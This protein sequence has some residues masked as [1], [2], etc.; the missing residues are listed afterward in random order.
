MRC[1]FGSFAKIIKLLY[2][3]RVSEKT[4]EGE[5]I[6]SLPEQLDHSDSAIKPSSSRASCSSR[7]HPQ[8][9]SSKED[10]DLNFFKILL[11]HVRTFFAFDK[12]EYRMRVMK[13]TQGFLKPREKQSSSCEHN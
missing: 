5:T 6:R 4:V 1:V 13:L 8:K 10:K 12:I 2:K 7:K 9:S 3:R 11:P